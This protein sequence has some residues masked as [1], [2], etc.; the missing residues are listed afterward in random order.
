MG[1]KWQPP[2]FNIRYRI[3]QKFPWVWK[4]VVSFQMCGFMLD[5]F[6]EISRGIY[7]PPKTNIAPEN[8][9]SQ[10][11]SSLPII[12]LEVLLLLVSGRV[13]PN[14]ASLLLEKLLAV[15][16]LLLLRLGHRLDAFEGGS[17][18]TGARFIDLKIPI[19]TD[20]R[21]EQF[22]LPTWKPHVCHGQKSRFFGDGHTTFNRNP[23]NGYINPYYWVD[24]HPL[25]YGNN[26]S[27]DSGTCR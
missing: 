11:E 5:M 26:G 16:K 19:M 27:L 24:D 6:F 2:N 8:R 1:K 23:Y 20:P 15:A 25:L 13:Y 4:N 21:E 7:T 18:S 14:H 10:K 17:S 22:F 3:P 12:N 9:P